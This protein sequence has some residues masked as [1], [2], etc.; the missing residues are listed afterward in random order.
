MTNNKDLYFIPIIARALNNVN[1]RDA[2]D[3]AFQKIRKLG[4][5]PE[6]FEGFRQFTE[7]VRAALKPSGVKG[8]Q[9]IQL[10]R[11]VIYRLLY[12]LATDT[13]MGTEEQGQTLIST[14]RS[15]PHWN[16]EYERIKKEAE[17]FPAHEMPLGI[18]ILKADHTLGSFPVSGLPDSVFSVSPGRYVSR[19]SNGRVL[20]EGVLTKE[21]LIWAFAYP[22]MDLP[23]AAKTEAGQQAPTRA[24]TLLEGEF[25]MYVFA[26]LEAG[27]IKIDAAKRISK[28]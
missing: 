13:F 18:E 9:G 16:A 12:D 17:A 3:D 21:E 7:F 27:E 24:I 6:Y 19:F 4:R 25:I 22:A 10:I 14:F 1:T 2:M 23:M 15:I 28:K 8:D 5:Q 20:W 26:G 11:D